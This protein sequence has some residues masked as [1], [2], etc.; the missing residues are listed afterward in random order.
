MS[1]IKRPM[2]GRASAVRKVMLLGQPGVGKTTLANSM[3][4]GRFDADYKRTIG[5]ELYTA[6][7]TFDDRSHR[8]VL[9]DT[10]GRIQDEMVAS[11]Y[12]KGAAGACVVADLTRP[13]TVEAARETLDIFEDLYPGRPA[14]LLGNKLDLMPSATL[15]DGT[16]VSVYDGTGVMQVFEDIAR[17]CFAD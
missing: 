16:C 11:S 12:C 17:E 4:F 2:S 15:D 7:I 13:E 1:L 10:D 9:W 8:L 14:R 3:A 5:V 6:D